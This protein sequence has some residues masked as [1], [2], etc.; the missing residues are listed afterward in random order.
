MVLDPFLG[1]GTSSVV[2]KKLGRQ[3]CGIELD[4]TYALLSEKRLTLADADRSIQGYLDRVFW[5]RNTLNSM[6]SS[7]GEEA[8]LPFDKLPQ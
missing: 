3:F 1:S 5:E 7:T 8:L 2:A 6:N 4:E